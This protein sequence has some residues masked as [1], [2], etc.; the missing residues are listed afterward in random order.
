LFL[1]EMYSLG[2]KNRVLLVEFFIASSQS[3]ILI[4]TFAYCPF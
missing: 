4:T 1:I 3:D 2:W